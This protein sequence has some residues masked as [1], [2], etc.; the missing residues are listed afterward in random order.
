VSVFSG[1]DILCFS[2]TD[3]HGKW[4]SRQ[5][6]MSRFARRGCRVLFV[7][8]PAGVEHLIRYPSLRRRKLQRWREGMHEVEP[9]VWIVSPPPLLPGRYYSRAVN[10]LNHAVLIS[11]SRGHV[12]RLNM[13]SPILWLYRPEQSPLLNRFHERLSVYHCIDEFAA[14]TQGRKRRTIRQLEGALLRRVDV[15]FANSRLTYASKRRLNADTHRIPSGADVEHFG[16]VADPDLRVDREMEAVPRPILAYVGN[17]SDRIDVGLLIALA[18]RHP[19]WS[20]VLIGQ[21]RP[22]TPKLGLLRSCPNVHL[23]GPRPF[24]ELPSLLKG[25]DVCLIPYAQNEVT[26]HASPLKLYEYLATGKPVVSTDQPEVREFSDLVYLAEDTRD[27]EEKVKQALSE[28]RSGLAQARLRAARGHSWDSRVD[29]MSSV[30][31][32]R[33]ADVD[34]PSVDQ[35]HRER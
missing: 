19:G 15:V 30:L 14:E 18:H 17:V 28:E 23:F 24:A 21:V 12:R 1:H 8:R 13:P 25:V 4:G 3:W 33:L 6:V 26:R 16:R 31:R 22:Q 20:L 32:R 35:T 5:Q 9:G 2:S 10:R 27:F 29:M 34:A 7:E 11:W